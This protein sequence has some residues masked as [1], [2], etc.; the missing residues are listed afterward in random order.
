MSLA[1]PIEVLRKRPA[2]QLSLSDEARVALELTMENPRFLLENP[3]LAIVGGPPIIIL[4]T[5]SKIA[6][7]IV[8][9]VL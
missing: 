2:E 3:L 1:E 8:R 5:F 4:G 6:S 7:F 9:N